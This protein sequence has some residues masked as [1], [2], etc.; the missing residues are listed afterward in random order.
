MKLLKQFPLFEIT[1][2]RLASRGVR[3]RKAYRLVGAYSQVSAIEKARK[4]FSA[5]TWRIDKVQ[6]TGKDVFI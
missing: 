4:T 5:G 3:A 1:A 2:T 6:Y